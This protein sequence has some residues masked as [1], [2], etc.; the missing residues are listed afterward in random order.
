MDR[1]VQC[2]SVSVVISADVQCQVEMAD[3]GGAIVIVGGEEGRR[4]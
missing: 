4:S 3:R 2:L 1:S